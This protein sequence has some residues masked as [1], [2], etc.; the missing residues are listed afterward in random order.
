MNGVP[1]DIYDHL[2]MC[3]FP[4]MFSISTLHRLGTKQKV[5]LFWGLFVNFRWCTHLLKCGVPLAK[6]LPKYH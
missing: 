4:E 2:Q 1:E 5:L 6:V 3:T